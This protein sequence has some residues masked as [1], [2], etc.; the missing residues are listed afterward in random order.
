MRYD[1]VYWYCEELL[2][3]GRRKLINGG[4]RN[5][6]AGKMGKLER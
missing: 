6:P 5:E 1:N 4:R 2:C 3:D